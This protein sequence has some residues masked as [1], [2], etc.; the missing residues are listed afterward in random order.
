[1][2]IMETWC[3]QANIMTGFVSDA[4]TLSEYLTFQNNDD[5]E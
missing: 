3:I 4:Q 1:M 2:E 5:L